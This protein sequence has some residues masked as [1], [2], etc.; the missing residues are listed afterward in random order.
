M[1]NAVTKQT[2]THG[3]YTNFYDLLSA[4]DGTNSL[5]SN[6]IFASMP[7][8]NLAEQSSYPIMILES[9]ETSLEQF[10]MGRNITEGTI[11]LNVFAATAPMRDQI[12]DKVIYAIETNK[13]ILATKNIRQVFIN[14]ITME[15]VARGKIK[16]N[17]CSIP[18][19]F[20]F[21]SEKT[22]AY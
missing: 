12:I 15:Q 2:I 11:V 13:G 5:F 22:F 9:P 3:I 21:Y 19:K 4:I 1:T 14:K 7:D 6:R 17:Y 18:I 20:K 8:V 10:D 16:V